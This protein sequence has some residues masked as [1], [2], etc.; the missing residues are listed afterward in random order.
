METFCCIISAPR[1]WYL[2][3]FEIILY[4][5]NRF[6]TPGE[7]GTRLFA[8]INRK[9]STTHCNSHIYYLLLYYYFCS[10]Y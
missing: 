3:I 10:L 6:S 4:N 7:R 5:E 1:G 2:T 8:Q 9:P